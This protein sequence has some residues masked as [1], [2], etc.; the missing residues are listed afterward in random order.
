MVVRVVCREQIVMDPLQADNSWINRFVMMTIGNC[1]EN[2]A[3]KRSQS[4]NLAKL[5][6]TYFVAHVRGKARMT[7]RAF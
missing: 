1:G 7:G 6:P 2:S 5:I 3:P 4:A